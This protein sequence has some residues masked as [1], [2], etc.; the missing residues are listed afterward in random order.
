MIIPHC[1]L[2]VRSSNID[3]RGCFAAQA[4]PA[5]AI[6]R[7]YTGERI[8]PGEADRREAD[9]TRPG[10]YTL[11]LDNGDVI[12]GWF[13]GNETIYLNH[14]CAPNCFMEEVAGR[15]YLGAEQAIAVG[16]ELTIDY[17]Y[18]PETPPEPCRCGAPVCRGYLNAVAGPA[19]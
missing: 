17:A 19:S 15:V 2:E 18:D 12:D 10:I 11:W 5:G 16:E 8:S 9:P 14:S 6:F 7:E 3:R 1:R 4:M 13:G